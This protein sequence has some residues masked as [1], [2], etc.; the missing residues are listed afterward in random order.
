MKR[1]INFKE[2]SNLEDFVKSEI[3]KN[4]ITSVGCRCTDLYSIRDN[5][6]EFYED[7]IL[8]GISTNSIGSYGTSDFWEIDDDGV[9]VDSTPTA[10]KTIFIDGCYEVVVIYE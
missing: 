2:I 3:L 5:G 4:G 7:G 8:L 6:E 9:I 10:D 1:V